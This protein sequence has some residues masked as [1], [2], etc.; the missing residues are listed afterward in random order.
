MALG[1]FDLIRRYFDRPVRRAL[2]GIGD[3]CALIDPLD[4][5][6]GA[7]STGSVLA[8]TSDMLVAGRHFFADAPPDSLGHKAL[9]VNLSDLAAMGAEPVGFTLALALPEIDEA[10]LA[11]FASGLHA[12]AQASDCELLG[13]DTTRGPLALCITA[14][15]SV[16]VTLA[17]RRD[18]ARAGDDVWVSG[19]LGGAAFAVREGLAGRPLATDHAARVRMEWP[20]PRLALGRALLGIAHAAIDVSDGLVADLGHVCA[21]SSL[22]AD[23]SWP[24]VPVDESLAGLTEAEREQLALGGGDD[25]ELIFTAPPERREAVRACAAGCATTVTRI[26]SLGRGEGVRVL[27][28]RGAA[29]PLAQRGFDH[30]A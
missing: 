21:R 3:D 22:A 1:E 18:A 4:P 27:D 26:G 24:A 15:G 30:F 17:L 14:M 9:A 8:V 29:L 20:Q 23:I 7:R 6:I 25:Y 2:L 13:G 19:S 5:R 11:A 12:L 28:A 16:P 10:W